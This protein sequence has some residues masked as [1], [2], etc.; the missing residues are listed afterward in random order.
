MKWVNA[1]YDNHSLL[2]TAAEET[3]ENAAPSDP[4]AESGAEAAG[5][6][7]VFIAWGEPPASLLWLSSAPLT[8][9]TH[10]IAPPSLLFSPPAPAEGS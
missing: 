4:P 10:V 9:N 8:Q 2:W 5:E 6:G 7:S 3:T 1:T